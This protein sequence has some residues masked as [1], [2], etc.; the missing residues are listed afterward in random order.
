M[1]RRIDLRYDKEEKGG[2]AMKKH[3]Y[4]GVG[5]LVAVGLL[6]GCTKADSPKKE[7]AKPAQ[8]TTLQKE[9]YKQEKFLLGTYTRIRIYDKGKEAALKPA[10]AR[11]EKLG[12]EITINDKGSEIDEINAQAG[13][14]PVKVTDDI[15]Y[16]L[17]E[18]Y[19]Y[20][21]KSNGG[22]NM[23]IGAITQLWRI[24]FADARKPAQA[25]IDEA[26]KHIDYHK[27]QFD[28][29]AKTVYLTEKGM[30]ID[31]GAIAK[32]YITDEVVKVLQKNKVSTAIVDLGGNVF[33]VG[34]SPRGTEEPWTIGIQDP[35]SARGN[36]LG[37][38]KETNKTVVTSGI[39]ERFLE[40]DGK[41]Y[42]HIFDSKTG[43]PYEND[44]ASVTVV[45][46]KSIDGDGLTTVVFDKGVKA[47]LE[48]I[49]KE[50]PKGTNAIFVTK[51][52]RVYVTDGLKNNFKL[53]GDSGFEMGQREELTK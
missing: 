12:D 14:Q 41:K 16:L 23:T 19:A 3:Y 53:G 31:L 29:Q 5:L 44:I 50:T 37:T 18:A 17:K 28:D 20:S 27:V 46:D 33:V 9:P 22:F 15:Y 4:W 6:A 35:N 47:G 24:G 26:L 2:K 32:G 1:L 39:Y 42:H 36:V 43:Y 8:T 40:V 11:I 7:E 45:T 34:H 51:E 48:Y 25:E 21:V 13:I 38:I 49:E 10:F 52:G 30:I